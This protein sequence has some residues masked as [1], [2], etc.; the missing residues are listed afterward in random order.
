MRR[1]MAFDCAGETLIGTLDHDGP[2]TVG[3]LIVSGGNEVRAG[4]HRGM[5]RL[6]ARLAEDGVPVF[7]YDRRGVGDSGG[8]NGGW[9]SA[10][11]DLAAALAVFRREAG[12]ARMIGFGNCDAASLLAIEGRRAGLEAVVLANPWTTEDEDGLPPAAAIRAGYAAKLRRPAE[13]A[14]L[15]RGGVDLRKLAR[16]LTKLARARPQPLQRRVVRAVAR[17]GERATI[18][19]AE[20]DATA[21]AFADAARGIELRGETIVIP[22]SSHGFARA[23]DQVALENAIRWA[24]RRLST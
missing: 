9:V 18:V 23:A 21:I 17:W 14:R 8:E 11:A 22:T 5:A 20:G 6:A 10:A 16:G 24:L 19:L 12:V 15:L 13:W 2:A 1:V 4:A 7:R 3:V